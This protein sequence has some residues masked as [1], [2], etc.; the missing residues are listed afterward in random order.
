MGSINTKQ[1]KEKEYNMSWFEIPVHNIERAA[2]FYSNI[3]SIKMEAI[4]LNGYSM[5]LFPEKT[6]IG[7]ALV[8]GP[9]CVPSEAGTLVYL[10]CKD[11]SKTISKIE[12]AGGRIVMGKT[13]INP[14][15]GYFALFIDSEGNK[16]ALHSRK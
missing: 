12:L 4:N 10:N 13:L 14:E 3:F 15:S 16:L 8:Q 11:L 7:G 2:L 1:I 5:A 9:G 6:G